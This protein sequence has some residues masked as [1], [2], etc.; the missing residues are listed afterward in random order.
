MQPVP[1]E[2]EVRRR[3]RRL[4]NSEYVLE[5]ISQR[6]ADPARIAFPKPPQ[7]SMTKAPNHNFKSIV[8]RSACQSRFAF[9]VPAAKRGSRTLTI[10]EIAVVRPLGGDPTLVPL[11]ETEATRPTFISGLFPTEMCRS[12][13][14]QPR[15]S[16]KASEPA[17]GRGQEQW[18][19]D[20]RR[21]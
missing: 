11:A 19:H 15:L 1:G 7:A 5:A 12:T 2:V 14:S 3:T 21:K 17:G 10:I 9:A 13:C 6:R 20:A 16:A 4:E 8:T 18:D